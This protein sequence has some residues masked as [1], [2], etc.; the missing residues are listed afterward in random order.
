MAGQG[1]NTVHG[2]RASNETQPVFLLKNTL[3]RVQ[4]EEIQGRKLILF[5]DIDHSEEARQVGLK[6]QEAHLLIFGNPK[7]GIPIMI[8][9]P[10]L[11]LDLPSKC[12]SG[13]AGMVAYGSAPTA[14]PT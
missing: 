11:A 12:S 2:R 3:A 1:R 8:A 10:L 9:S 4:E 6:M 13:R 14:P 7:A 5:S